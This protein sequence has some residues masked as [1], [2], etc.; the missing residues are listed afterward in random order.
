MAPSTKNSFLQTSAY[1]DFV[2]KSNKHV[3]HEKGKDFEYFAVRTD[4]PLGS[5]LYCPYG[6]NLDS[7]PKTSLRHALKS[8]KELARK[9][10]CIFIRIEPR[11]PFSGEYLRSLG[12]KKSKNISPKDT[13]FLDLT[14]D[15][16]EIKK[17]FS[18]GVK[19]D[20]NSFSRKGIKIIESKDKKYLDALV[21]FQSQI[22]KEKNLITLDKEYLRSQIAEDFSHLYSAIIEENGKE[23]IIAVSLFF[24]DEENGT[25]LY[26]QSSSDDAYH[27]LPASVAILATAIF[28]AKE[29]GLTLFDFWGIAPDGAPSSH[30]WFGFTRFKKSFG[31]YPVHF[32]GTFDLPLSPR[33]P[34]YQLTRK[35]NLIS[36]RLKNLKNAKNV[37]NIKN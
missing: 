35:L 21:R 26:M 22:F 16:A 3:F 36:R 31:G 2:S 28:D 23:K 12:L 10:H 24:D 25:R 30:P 37:N 4:T 18:H 19:S 6:P 11:F 13:L 9:E 33:Y 7:S 1:F 5:Y 17:S 34:L 8:L 20:F 14:P 15:I 29:K 27:R 32:S